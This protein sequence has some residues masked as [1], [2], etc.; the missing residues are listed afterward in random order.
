MILAKIKKRFSDEENREIALKS[1]V[2]F[3]LRISGFILNY[4]LLIYVS[5]TF[6]SG[7]WGIYSILQSILYLLSSA[8]T[9]GYTQ[10]FIKFFAHSSTRSFISYRFAAIRILLLSGT[11]AIL[12]Y[13]F[14]NFIASFFK[15][16]VLLENSIKYLAFAIVPFCI[17][18]FHAALLKSVKKTSHYNFYDTIGRPLFSLLFVVI[19]IYYIDSLD[20]M[21]LSLVFASIVMLISSTYTIWPYL[22][23]A[24][25]NKWLN[26]EEIKSVSNSLYL[27][28]FF[29][30]GLNYST[31]VILGY[32]MT[33]SDVGIFDTAYRIVNFT[34]IVLYAVNSISA[35]K[36]ANFNFDKDLKKLQKNIDFT[37]KLIFWFSVPTIL[38]LLLSSH[39][40]LLYFGQ[41]YLVG[42]LALVF[43]LFGQVINNVAGSVGQM[44]QMTGYHKI[45]R[46]INF[47]SLA[48]VVTLSIILIPYFGISG[49]GFAYGFSLA[50]KNILGIIMIKNKLQIRTY[51]LPKFLS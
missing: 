38:I 10:S 20:I 19:A 8:L 2:A 46:N 51:Y 5:K 26:H 34:A 17:V 30:K 33:T 28:S 48:S 42:N 21:A 49:A 13:S 40:I 11:V 1:L 39:W 25:E 3:L 14:S 15:D 47:V 45:I 16:S 6:Q 12:F 29:Q 31:V 24:R 9:L 37:S 50:L 7:G 36:F 27:S 44:M 22:K 43:M 41:E 18:Q 35:P 23:S 4:A 32:F